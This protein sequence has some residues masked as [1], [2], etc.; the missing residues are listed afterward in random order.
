MTVL[1]TGA[2]GYIGS[3][4]MVSLVKAGKDVVAADNYC[5]SKPEA[6]RCVAE[7][8]GKVFP[9]YEVDVRDR[10]ALGRIFAAHRVDAVIHFAGLKAVGESV[11]KPLEYYDNNLLSTL[12]LV[13]TM[14]ANCC[15]HLVFS[16]SATVYGAPKQLPIKE[17]APLSA[18]NPYGRTKLFI[19]EI[20]RDVARA[21]ERWKIALLRY[22]NPVG[23]HPSGMLGE[24]PN[25]TPNNLFPYMSKVAE[26]QLPMLNVFGG[27]Y[28]TPDGT[29]V[30]DYIHVC[31]LAEGH[32]KAIESIGSFVGTEAI[33]LGTGCGYSVLAAIK[34]FEQASGK[35][36]PYQ[37]AARRQG[38]VAEC[39]ADT[40]RAYQ[41]LG[42]KAN[43]GLGDM[44]RDMWR[45]EQMNRRG[46]VSLSPA[47]S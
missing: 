5:N 35:K 32:V 45:W 36:V 27:D 1:V 43:R 18:T 11:Q 12:A 42:W 30:R 38:D 33:N 29:G 22:F 7:V 2:A 41:R 37:I 14:A 28:P 25:G 17:D 16:S 47:G 39:Y 31:D 10:A 21:D 40:Q 19:E 24:I 9:I 8:T 34:E 23:A 13:Q 46:H 15:F 26:G 20:L 3:H 44:C 4:T 6:L